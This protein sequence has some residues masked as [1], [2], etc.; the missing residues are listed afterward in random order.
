M[1]F[2]LSCIYV[3]TNVL[4][5]FQGAYDPYTHIYT[6]KDIADIIEF[7]RRRGIRVVPEFDTPGIVFP[8]DAPN[9]F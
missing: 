5:N 4:Y 9:L 8:I 6:Q 1:F 7:A 2:F 3:F